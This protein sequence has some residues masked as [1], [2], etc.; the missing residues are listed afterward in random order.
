[1]ISTHILDTSKGMP[2]ANVEVLLEKRNDNLTWS[3][4]GLE[5]TNADGRIVFDCPKERGV[6]KLTFKIEK[7]FEKEQSDFFFMDTPV[8][9]QVKTTDRKYHVPL[10]LNPFGISSYRGS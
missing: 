8:I 4:I 9:F 2:A 3:K 1:M 10:L 5:M 6:Y 7:Y